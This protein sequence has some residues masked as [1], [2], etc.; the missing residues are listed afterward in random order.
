MS[1]QLESSS[2]NCCATLRRVNCRWFGA[3]AKAMAALG[4][5]D[6]QS[7]QPDRIKAQQS[8]SPGAAT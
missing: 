6:K 2:L 4:M 7:C 8:I 5:H 3:H 1:R